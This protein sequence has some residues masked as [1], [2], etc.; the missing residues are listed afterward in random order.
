MRSRLLIAAAI[1]SFANPAVAEDSA[2]PGVTNP[3]A[4]LCVLPLISRTVAL[5]TTVPLGVI[6]MLLL[7]IAIIGRVRA[8]E[9]AS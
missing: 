4:V 9:G 7:L 5:Y 2:A 8:R 1:V 6:V 3:D